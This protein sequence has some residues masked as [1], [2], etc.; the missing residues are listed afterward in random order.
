MDIQKLAKEELEKNNLPTLYSYRM[1]FTAGYN[2]ALVVA[3]DAV[4]LE[5]R[6]MISTSE[7]Q[8]YIPKAAARLIWDDQRPG[9]EYHGEF[10]RDES[11]R[12]RVCF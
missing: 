2:A 5:E 10:V 8:E 1:A 6:G 3:H 4:G 9:A 7:F 11:G 12:T